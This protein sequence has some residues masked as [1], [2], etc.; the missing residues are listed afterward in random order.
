VRAES[1]KGDLLNDTH[2]FVLEQ[3]A[4]KSSWVIHSNPY[5]GGSDHTVF[6]GAGIPSVLDWHF[7]D[8]YY[9]SN[10]DTPDKT[11]PDEMRNV[12]V[13]CRRLGVAAGVGE[14]ADRSRRRRRGRGGRTDANRSRDQG[15]ARRSQRPPTTRKRLQEARSDDSRGVA[16]LVRRSGSEVVATRDRNAAGFVQR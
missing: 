1:L 9:H 2:W 16:E 12:G 3:V 13:G 10:L 15:K 5:E 4:T 8:R 7:T 6:Q 14:P 11:S